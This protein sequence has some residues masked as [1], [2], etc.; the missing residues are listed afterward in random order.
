MRTTTSISTPAFLRTNLISHSHV[1]RLPKKT[2]FLLKKGFL[3]K[4]RFSFWL[5]V[6][7]CC[8]VL[9]GSV[10]LDS[11]QPHGLQPAMLLGPWGF[12]KQEYWSGLPFPPLGDL[13][14]PGIK[15]RSPALQVNSS[16]S[17]PPGKPTNTGVGSLSLLQGIFL[18]QESNWGLRCRRIF[19]QLSY[20][21][22][23]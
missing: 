19:Y 20:Q 1:H 17:E 4:N 16:P 21:G 2:G 18:T 9:S 22:N 11:L 6:F 10:V 7:I 5:Q 23:P 13:P 15:P 8:A 12:S 3:L 14:N